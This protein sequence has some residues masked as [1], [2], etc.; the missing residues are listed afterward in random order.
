MVGEINKKQEQDPDS[1]YVPRFP[2]GATPP[3]TRTA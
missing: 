1:I 2:S 3:R